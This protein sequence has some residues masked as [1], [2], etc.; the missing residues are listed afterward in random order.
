MSHTQLI[1]SMYDAFSRGD[2]AYI[3]AHVAPGASWRQSKM[4]PWGGDYTGPEGAREFFGKLAAEMETTA[5]RAH[6]N[7][8][9]GD[10]VFSFGYYEGRSLSTGK[11]AGSEW[12]FRWRI[13]D[14]KIAGY[15]AYIDTA[16]MLAVIAPKTAAVG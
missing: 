3:L 14:G 10:E 13:A 11:I 15:E 16:A 6:Q 1:D 5:F 8:E 2:I 12:M 4:L 9:V 7:I